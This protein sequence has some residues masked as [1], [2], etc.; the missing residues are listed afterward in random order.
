VLPLGCAAK[1]TVNMETRVGK[2]WPGRDSPDGGA[3]KGGMTRRGLLT[4]ASAATLAAG[5]RADAAAYPVKPIQFM[6]PFTPG[7]GADTLA[8]LVA[9]DVSARLGQT[10][11]IENRA[12]A[13]GNIAAQVV[14]H[15]RP[16]G[17]TLLEGNLAHAIAMTMNRRRTYDIIRDFAPITELGSVPFALCVPGKSELRTVG[18]L[19]AAAKANPDKLNYAS[20]GIGGPSHLAMELFKSMTG[21]QIVHVPYKGASPAMEDLMGGRVQLAFLTVPAMQPLLRSGMLRVLGVASLEPLATVPG[22][23]AIAQ[24]GVPGFE[25]STWFGVMAP[26]GTPPD[27]IKTLNSAF[28]ASLARPETRA[29]LEAEGFALAGGSPEQFEAY[30]AAETRKWAP[31]VIAAGAVVD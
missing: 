11:V 18:D 25:A 6:V 17:Y 31:V 21:V 2:A 27:I 12:G 9:T 26:A 3:A 4:C 24:S 7:G 13:G 29:R 8:R 19:I 10:V 20:S 30:I 28:N 1:K 15:A 23:P 5:G 14:S 22:V 16:D